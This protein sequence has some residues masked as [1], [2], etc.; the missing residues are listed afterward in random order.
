M[1]ITLQAHR[2]VLL[3][4]SRQGMGRLRHSIQGYGMTCI[5]GAAILVG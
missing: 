1:L 3:P 4:A 2:D 5:H